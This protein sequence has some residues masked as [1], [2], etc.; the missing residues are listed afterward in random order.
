[1]VSR[2]FVCGVDKGTEMDKKVVALSTTRGLH[3]AL[4]LVIP[5]PLFP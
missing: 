4:V 2:L 5:F 1:M 3:M